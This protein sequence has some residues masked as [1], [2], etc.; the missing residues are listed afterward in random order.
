[1]TERVLCVDDDLNVLEAYQRTLCRRFH[2][3]SALDGDEALAAVISRGPY[4]VVVADMRMPGMNGVRLLANVKEIA[5][6]TVRMMLTGHADQQTALDAVND[7]YVFRFMTKPCPPEEFA[8]A[9]KAGIAQYRLIT[10]EREL[11]SKTL[12]GSVKVLTDVLALVNPDAFG[13]ASRVY[14]LV[15]QLCKELKLQKT[16][17]IEIAAMLSQIGCVAVPEGAIAKVYQGEPLSPVESL[18]FQRHP[19]V[20]RELLAKI[21]RLEEAAEIIAYQD[22]RYDGKG[23]PPDD[24]RSTEIPLGSRILKAALDLDSLVATGRTPETAL[25]EIHA[26]H[27]WY[28]P[29]VVAALKKVLS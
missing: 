4:A 8:R 7:G 14:H 24:V 6:D 10:A 9:L 3:E 18:A 22:K 27:G 12:T 29:V 11:L 15:L 1:M 16:W 28:D 23:F 25:A 13:R 19:E 21:P 2:I 17:P 20:G 5:P 26:R